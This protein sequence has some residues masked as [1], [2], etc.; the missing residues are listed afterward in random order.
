MFGLCVRTME[1]LC[2]AFVLPSFNPFS[3]EQQY[4]V[5]SNTCEKCLQRYIVAFATAF[6]YLH[7]ERTL[8]QNK[9]IKP[10]K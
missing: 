6:Y 3:I 5:V 8:S 1:R 10:Y 4:I 7:H 9:F 2:G